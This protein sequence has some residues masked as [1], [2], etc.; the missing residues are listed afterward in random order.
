MSDIKEM[1]DQTARSAAVAP[2]PDVVDADVRRGQAALI[3]RRRRRAVGSSI[4]STLAAAAVVATAIVVGGPDGSS[5][6]PAARPD[7]APSEKQASGVRLVTYTGEQSDGFI[8]DKVPE[9]WYVQENEHSQYS[10]T[11]APKGDTSDADVF[12]DKLVVMLDTRWPNGLPK[13]EPVEVNGHPGVIFRD[14]PAGDQLIFEY[15]DGRYVVVQSWNPI[16][17]WY[18]DQLVSFAEGVTVTADAK[19]GIG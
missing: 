9:G 11:I 16:L 19:T 5:D 14:D 3:R 4:A 8:V 13:G 18:D 6:A 12:V 15:E 2:A 17:D 1:L 10:L 7:P